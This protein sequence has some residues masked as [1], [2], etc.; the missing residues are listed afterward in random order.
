M[1]DSRAYLGQCAEPGCFLRAHSETVPHQGRLAQSDVTEQVFRPHVCDWGGQV[2][3][4]T[5]DALLIVVSGD[6]QHAGLYLNCPGCGY[7]PDREPWA[8]TPSML[9][10][11]RCP[12]G[13][14]VP[15]VIEKSGPTVTP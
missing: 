12:C 14:T 2:F 3:E 4:R 11:S 10:T 5:K 15:H 9:G 13:I 1:S 6:G 7:V 8:Y